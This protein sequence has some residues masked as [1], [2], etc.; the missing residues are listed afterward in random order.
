MIAKNIVQP[1]LYEAT[2]QFRNVD[3]DKPDGPLKEKRTIDK[4]SFRLKKDEEDSIAIDSEK[5]KEGT[6]KEAKEKA[7]DEESPH[8][9][10]FG[11]DISINEI[12]FFKEELEKHV[13]WA[14]PLA[15]YPPEGIWLERDKHVFDGFRPRLLTLRH[16]IFLAAAESLGQAY[17]FFKSGRIKKAKKRLM[18]VLRYTIYCTQ[19]AD[20]Y[21]SLSLSLSLSTLSCTHTYT[22]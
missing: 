20:R 8:R 18:F 16:S 21:H 10:T 15:S 4:Q 13:V 7:E 19:I 2:L 9:E 11:I 17:H 5:E 3:I 14:L 6:K 12:N 22:I 1:D